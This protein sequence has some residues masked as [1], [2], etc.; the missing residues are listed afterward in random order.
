MGLLI[1]NE[2]ATR[3]LSEHAIITSI[4]MLYSWYFLSLLRLPKTRNQTGSRL[5]PGRRSKRSCISASHWPQASVSQL[6][7]QCGAP[8]HITTE[9][10]Y[11]APPTVRSTH[12]HHNGVSPYSPP[13]SSKE[14]LR[15]IPPYQE[16]MKIPPPFESH[17]P[18]WGKYQYNGI[19]NCFISW[20]KQWPKT[21]DLKYYLTN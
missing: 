16:H 2:I 12:A 11:T 7:Q 1:P 5:L 15:L 8:T 3:W 17:L 4:L 18:G 9:L 13:L 6:L 14:P 20:R 21:R 10:H 19:L